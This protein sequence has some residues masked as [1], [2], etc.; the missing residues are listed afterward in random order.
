MLISKNILLMLI[1]GGV[2]TGKT[3]FLTK[4]LLVLKMA[5]KYWVPYLNQLDCD[6]LKVSI[7]FLRN[8][9]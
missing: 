8:W 9:G 2:Q 3:C 6:F 5:L 7:E 4:R 1:S